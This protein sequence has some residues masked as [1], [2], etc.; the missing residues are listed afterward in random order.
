MIF[1]N[2]E[3]HVI[4]IITNRIFTSRFSVYFGDP[5]NIIIIFYRKEDRMAPNIKR[6]EDEDTIPGEVL[7]AP[8]P[9]APAPALDNNFPR[10]P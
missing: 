1:V 8:A 4:I 5:Q 2:K 9:P 7:F 6:E 10:G 3:P